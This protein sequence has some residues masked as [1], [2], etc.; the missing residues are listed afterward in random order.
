MLFA[1]VPV[2]VGIIKIDEDCFRLVDRNKSFRPTYIAAMPL[3]APD[4]HRS[5]KYV[6]LVLHASTSIRTLAV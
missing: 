1:L 2:H 3:A 5:S 6:G 4:D